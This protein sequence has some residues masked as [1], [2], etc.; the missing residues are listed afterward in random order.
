MINQTFWHVDV[1]NI[2]ISHEKLDMFMGGDQKWQYFNGKNLTCWDVDVNNIDISCEKHYIFSYVGIR[3]VNISLE[4]LSNVRCGRQKFEYIS[5]EKLDMFISGDQ[6]CTYFSRKTRYFEMWTSEM[7][8]FHRK[9]MICSCW[10]LIVALAGWTRA[11]EV[12]RIFML[13]IC[14]LFCFLSIN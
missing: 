3:H 1:R 5:Y 2:Y 12:L 4:I 13:S 9:K 14:I 10:A 6:K 11:L 7:P 8:I